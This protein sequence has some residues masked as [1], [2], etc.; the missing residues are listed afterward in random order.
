MSDNEKKILQ[1]A[2]KQIEVPEEAL[3]ALEIGSGQRKNRVRNFRYKSGEIIL[4][5]IVIIAFIFVGTVM[6]TKAKETNNKPST[7]ASTAT[8]RKKET[9]ANILQSTKYWKVQNEEDYY[10]FGNDKVRIIEHYFSLFTTNYTFK[11]DQLDIIYDSFNEADDPI[12]KI[13]SYQ[14]KKNGNN[15]VLEPKLA[16]DKRLILEPHNE[17]IFPYSEEK[18]KQLKPAVDPDLTKYASWTSSIKGNRQNSTLMFDGFLMKERIDGEEDWVTWTYEIEGNHLVVN[19]G[20]YTVSHDMY[21][22]GDTIILWQVSNS[23]QKSDDKEE[24]KEE[25]VTILQPNK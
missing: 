2:M 17:E 24:Y 7:S 6:W 20:G 22:D 9:P 25:I 1:K 10:S 14:V 21:W 3:T 11:G 12:E 4:S 19:Y 15:L 16:E 18:I 5:S 13:H 8:E 23:L